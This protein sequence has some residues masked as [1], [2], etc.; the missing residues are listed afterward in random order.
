VGVG[1]DA[2]VQV[3]WSGDRVDLE[4]LGDLPEVRADVVE[5]ALGD[6]EADEGQDLVAH[7]PQVEVGVE[8]DDD[9]PLLELVEARLY[10]PACDAEL[11]GELHHAG[12]GRVAQRPDEPGVE[13]IDSP[14]QHGQCVYHIRHIAGQS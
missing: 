10:R 8:A 13:R 5:P 9:A 12:A 6:L 7:R 2:A 3:A 1:D 11:A 14:G 4:D